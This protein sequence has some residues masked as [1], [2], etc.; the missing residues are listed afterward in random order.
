[1]CCRE[2]VGIEEEGN[3]QLIEP[4][5]HDVELRRNGVRDRELLQEGAQLASELRVC[6]SIDVHRRVH[7][8]AERKGADKGVKPLGVQAPTLPRR[9]T[10]LQIYSW[11]ACRIGAGVECVCREAGLVQNVITTRF[12]EALG[13]GETFTTLQ[14]Y[15]LARPSKHEQGDGR[16]ALRH[17]S[18]ARIA[19]R[20]VSVVAADKR[21]YDWLL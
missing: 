10:C 2:E 14:T 18:G 15:T 7:R 6:R 20:G 13:G 5:L 16:G 3:L 12:S 1:M 8:L 19:R 11:N 9:S 21:A 4:E 17:E